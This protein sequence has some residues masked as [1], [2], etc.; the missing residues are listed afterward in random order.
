MIPYCPPYCEADPN[1]PP[2]ARHSTDTVPGRPTSRTETD[3]QTSTGSSCFAPYPEG[4]SA[5]RPA[6]LW[7]VTLCQHIE[8]RA[9]VRVHAH[10]EEQARSKALAEDIVDEHMDWRGDEVV[11]GS[12]EVHHMERVARD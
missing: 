9:R 8:E 6:A 1:G 12:R 3:P 2:R 10:N 4:A 11:P 5:P 7:E